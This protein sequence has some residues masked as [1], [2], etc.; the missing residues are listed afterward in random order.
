MTGRLDG[1]RRR[2]AARAVAFAVGGAVGAVGVWLVLAWLP[3]VSSP[4]GPLVA[5]TALSTPVVGLPLWRAVVRPP[6]TGPWWGGLVGA[7]IPLVLTVVVAV[8]ALVV[9]DL[10]A[11]EVGAAAALLSLTALPLTF[12]LAVVGAA[13]EAGRHRGRA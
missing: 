7:W 1:P 2:W 9:G 5:S 13:L 8:V 3:D 6:R 4:A 12:V 10:S 11:T